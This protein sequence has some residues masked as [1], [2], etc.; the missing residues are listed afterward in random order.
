MKLWLCITIPVGLYFCFQMSKDYEGRA[1]FGEFGHLLTTV[2]CL[3]G[4]VVASVLI[5]IAPSVV[6]CKVLDYFCGIQTSM[7]QAG[8]ARRRV[9]EQAKN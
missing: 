1:F 8:D 7:R 3:P 6:A 5:Y 4:V 2:L 9:V